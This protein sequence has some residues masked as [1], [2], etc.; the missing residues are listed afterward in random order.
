MEMLETQM[1]E[2]KRGYEEILRQKELHIQDLGTE[3][4]AMLNEIERRDE[5][6]QVLE[7]RVQ[8]VD[9]DIKHLVKELNRSKCLNSGLKE[10][11]KQARAREK[12]VLELEKRL[13]VD[14]DKETKQ[15][16]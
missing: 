2:M 10:E 3:N 12:I 11:L 8:Q 1:E 7:E 13:N 5:G 16:E 9:Q 4:L 15:R 6:H 14:K